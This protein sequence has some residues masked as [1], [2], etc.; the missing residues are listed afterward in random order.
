[1]LTGMVGEAPA[2]D[3]LYFQRETGRGSRKIS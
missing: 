3:L 1:M 2:L